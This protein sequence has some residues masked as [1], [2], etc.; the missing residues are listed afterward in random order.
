MG[1]LA[2]LERQMGSED[3]GGTKL[4]EDIRELEK[5]RVA[6][7]NER[8]RIDRLYIRG[9]RSEAELDKFVREWK[10]ESESIEQ[11]LGKLR[12]MAANRESNAVALNNAQVLLKKLRSR[13]DGKLPFVERRRIVEGLVAG[14]TVYMNQGAPQAHVRYRFDSPVDRLLDWNREKRLTHSDT[15][16]RADWD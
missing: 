10:E 16:T 14:I 15:G 3:D 8:D 4:R 2:E 9:D 5:A 1:L 13:L 7:A 6:K 12:Q 11:E